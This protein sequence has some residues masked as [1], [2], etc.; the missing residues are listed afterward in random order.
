MNNTLE[1]GGLGDSPDRRMAEASGEIGLS[2][3]VPRYWERIGVVKPSRDPAGRRHFS[4]HD[5]LLIPLVRE[6]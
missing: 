5:L 2:P 1:E 4:R 3:R 6:V